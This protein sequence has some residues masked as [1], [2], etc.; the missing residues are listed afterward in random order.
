MVAGKTQTLPWCAGSRAAAGADAGPLSSGDLGSSSGG[1][2]SGGPAL[3]PLRRLA[4]VVL[5]LAARGGR[6]L[7]ALGAALAARASAGLKAA[8]QL[9]G[10]SLVMGAV[11]VLGM[12]LVSGVASVPGSR[13]SAV[14]Q[15]V[16]ALPA[17]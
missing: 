12:A 5:R 3:G 10:G 9:K 15:E 14:P 8:L 6:L 13:Y 4:L 17:L 7:Q 2:D 16:R 1:D 11:F